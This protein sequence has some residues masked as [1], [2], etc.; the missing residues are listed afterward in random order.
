MRPVTPELSTECAGIGLWECS[1]LRG[2][3]HHAEQGNFNVIA[4]STMK[5]R[6]ARKKENS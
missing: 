4:V 2:S 3:F 6:Y 1:E 5:V